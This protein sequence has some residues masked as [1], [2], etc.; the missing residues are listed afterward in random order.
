MAT[1]APHPCAGRCGA[2][3][4]KG[5]GAR[6]AECEK[7]YDRARGNFRERGY[8]SR[9]DA[10][11]KQHLSKNP[12]CVPCE[13]QWK[14]T[15]ANTVDHHVAWQTGIDDAAKLQLKYDSTNLTAMCAS[16][17]GRKTAL[18]DRGFGRASTRHE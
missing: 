11:R 5:Q 6:C 4:P 12:L 7:K 17:H 8:D 9:W 3:V 13:Q 18:E 2:R 10:L 16:C 1:G 15:A 14:I